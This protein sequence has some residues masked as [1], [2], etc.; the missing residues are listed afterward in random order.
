MT[1]PKIDQNLGRSYLCRIVFN[2]SDQQKY[3]VDIICTKWTRLYH[4]V[5]KTELQFCA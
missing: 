1:V 5:D 3:N 4:E 2:C